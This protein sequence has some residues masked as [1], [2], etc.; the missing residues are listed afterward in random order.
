[1]PPKRKKVARNQR[2]IASGKQPF[3]RVYKTNWKNKIRTVYSNQNYFMPFAIRFCSREFTTSDTF[4]V[5]LKQ[6]LISCDHKNLS[7]SPSLSLSLYFA[8][9]EYKLLID[10]L[11]ELCQSQ[12]VL[13]NF[14]QYYLLQM[15][16]CLDQFEVQM[17]RSS[18]NW[19]RSYKDFTT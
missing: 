12:Q 3:G 19:S 13:L 11:F 7:L 9:S 15:A 16:N 17:C 2:K 4:V 8:D 18:F 1:M 6:P 10:T 5:K 14:F